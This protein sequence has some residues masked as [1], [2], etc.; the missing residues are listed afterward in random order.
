VV[1]ASK[2]QASREKCTP[3]RPKVGRIQFNRCHDAMAFLEVGFFYF[4]W[5]VA[6]AQFGLQVPLGK[7]NLSGQNSSET[8]A[9]DPCR[10]AYHDG[11]LIDSKGRFGEPGGTRTRYSSL[12][13]VTYGKREPTKSIKRLHPPKAAT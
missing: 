1:S 3:A 11:W 7:W 4:T 10:N 9:Q 5:G 13:S 8:H 6:A 12:G 2:G